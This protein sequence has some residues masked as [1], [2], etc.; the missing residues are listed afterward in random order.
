MLEKANRAF[1]D[2]FK[3][4]HECSLCKRITIDQALPAAERVR[5]AEAAYRLHMT[6]L[7]L[8]A[9]AARRRAAEARD[10]ADQAEAELRD[11]QR[12]DHAV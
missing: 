11:L 6:R 3:T 8:K 5:Q 7:S 1:Q 4:G 2:S 9:A 12:D 10:I